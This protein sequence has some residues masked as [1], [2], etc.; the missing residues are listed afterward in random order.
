MSWHYRRV[1]VA[2]GVNVRTFLHFAVVEIACQPEIFMSVRVFP[3][4]K[5]LHPM[6]FCVATDHH[7]LN[8][9][10]FIVFRKIDVE[11]H[12]FGKAFSSVFLVMS[13]MKLSRWSK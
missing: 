7:A 12:A 2:D 4:V 9:F 13:I 8:G 10:V 5:V 11:A 6:P 1:I 3:T